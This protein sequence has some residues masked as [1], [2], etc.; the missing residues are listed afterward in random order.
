MMF[1]IE[2]TNADTRP[3]PIPITKDGGYSPSGSKK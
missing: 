3:K 1:L 2:K